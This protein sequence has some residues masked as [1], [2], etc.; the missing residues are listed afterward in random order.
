MRSLHLNKNLLLLALSTIPLWV[1]HTV[2]KESNLSDADKKRLPPAVNRPVDFVKD[3][4]PIFE[5]NCVKCH[6]PEKQKGGLR[7][8]I[9]AIALKGGDDYAPVIVPGKS[10]DSPLIHFVA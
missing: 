10:A 3:I 4:K 6:G 1:C 2:A 5:A 8:D 7:L 9:K